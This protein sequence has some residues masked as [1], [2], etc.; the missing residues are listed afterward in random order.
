M[1]E[2]DVPDSVREYNQ[3]AQNL[4]DALGHPCLLPKIVHKND[5]E[6]NDYNPNKVP[7]TELE[8]LKKSIE[9]DG[10]TMPIV[11]YQRDDGKYEVVDGFHRYE[12]LTERLDEGWIPISV[13]DKPQGERMASTVR[14]NRARGD[15]QTELM[16]QLVE[17]MEEEGKT[18][19]E[20]ADD[21]GMEKEEVVRLKQVIG[22]SS[23]L[24]GNEY[25]QSWGVQ[26]DE[27][28]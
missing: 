5:V 19:E 25:T 9:S 6:P 14:H 1:T 17:S 16:G 3:A 11:T 20:L 10:M 7:D 8:L 24:A 18:T 13:I 4:P 21:L 15:H 23:M 26:N 2:Q 28:S 12:V 22:A 27:D